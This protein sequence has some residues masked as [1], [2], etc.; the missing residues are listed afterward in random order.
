MTDV[1]VIEKVNQSKSHNMAPSNIK[2]NP[3][4]GAIC[5]LAV[6]CLFLYAFGVPGYF[7]RHAENVSMKE[8]LSA[9]IVLARRGGDRVREI[10]RADTLDARV[11]GETKEG[12]KEFVSKG[13]MASHDQ[14]FYGLAKEFPNMNVSNYNYF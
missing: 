5:I 13:D 9:S 7:S 8:L 1:F 12:A 3:I 11:K 10:R 14:I 2:I 6:L 4:G